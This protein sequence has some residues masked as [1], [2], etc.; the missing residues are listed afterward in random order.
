MIKV[1]HL[2]GSLSVG[3]AQMQVVHLLNHLDTLIFKRHLIV[4]WDKATEIKD[5]LDKEVQY[6]AAQYR[7]R[8]LPLGIFRLISFLKNHKI[9]ILHCHI[10][11]FNKVGSLVGRLARVPVI[12]TGERGRNPWK[13]WRHHIVE[14]Y[15]ISRLVTKRVAVS[16]DIRKLRIKH[17]GVRPDQIITIPN[18]VVL[19]DYTADTAPIPKV[20]GSLGRL[21]E[22]KDYPSLFKAVKILE[23]NGYDLQ[24]QIAGEGPLK[25]TLQES[26]YDL[27][28]NEKIKLVGFQKPESFLK[29][30]DIFALPSIRE[31]M[32]GALLEAMSHGIPVVA[33]TAG[34]ILEVIQNGKD[35]LL[36]EP[37][38]PH[39]MAKNI[40]LMIENMQLR[41]QLALNAREKIIEKYTIDK[42]ANQYGELYVDLLDANW[43]KCDKKADWRS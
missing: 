2:I 33:T 10:Y 4:L 32:P 1:A 34:G 36:S 31:G 28:M 40:Q 17:D 8:T 16:H 30:I 18:G 22:A 7:R 11:D 15:I 9:D 43:R 20:I 26:I 13:K 25:N 3:G 41:K 5:C 19:P 38:Q 23:Q 14:K 39:A 27:R 21:V 6:Y 12:I 29:K 42:I 35:G 24:L 37:Q